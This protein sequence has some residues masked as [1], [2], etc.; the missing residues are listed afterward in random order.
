MVISRPQFIEFR[1]WL[2]TI[3]SAMQMA[4]CFGNAVEVQGA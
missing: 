4:I 3:E 2:P 1:V